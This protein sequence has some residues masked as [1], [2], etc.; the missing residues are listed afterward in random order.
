LS[1]HISEW[2]ESSLPMKINTKSIRIFFF[3]F[4]IKKGILPKE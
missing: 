4:L 2:D 3:K 1:P